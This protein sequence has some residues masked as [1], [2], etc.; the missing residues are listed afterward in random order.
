MVVLMTIEGTQL[1]IH[2]MP[3]R[4]KFSRLLEP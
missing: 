2:A 1:V 3:M 4:A